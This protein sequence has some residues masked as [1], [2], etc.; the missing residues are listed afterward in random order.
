MAEAAALLRGAKRPVIL[1]GRVYAR[2]RSPGTRRVA[3]AEALGARVVTDLKIGAAFPTDH[4]LHVGAARHGSLAPE[5][6]AT[7]S[8]RPT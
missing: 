2:P 8:A 6:R 1:A 3:L 4:R 5:S 7:P